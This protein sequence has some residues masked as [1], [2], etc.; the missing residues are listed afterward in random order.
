MVAEIAPLEV[1]TSGGY[2]SLLN[3]HIFTSCWVSIFTKFSLRLERWS[4]KFN[5]MERFVDCW[6]FHHYPRRESIT[7]GYRDRSD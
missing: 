4:K 6:A 7:R 2:D 1:T 3:F 5:W